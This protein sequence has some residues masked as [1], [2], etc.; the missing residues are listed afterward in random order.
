MKVNIVNI[1]NIVAVR[2]KII[3]DK[4]SQEANILIP[5]IKEKSP[6]LQY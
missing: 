4:D 6:V 3:T 2:F 1:R 5:N